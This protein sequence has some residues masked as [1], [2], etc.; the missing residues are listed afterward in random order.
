MLDVEQW[1]SFQRTANGRKSLW[2]VAEIVGGRA[3]IYDALIAACRAH[4]DDLDRIAEDVAALGYANAAAI[5]AE[6]LPQTARA[7][8]GE[9][10]EILATE[11]VENQ[12]D[13]EVPIRRLRYKDG[14]EMALRGDDFIG[15]QQDDVNQLSFLKG[16]AKSRQAMDAATIEEAR[17]VLSRDDGRPTPISLLFVADQLI[18]KGEPYANLG[19][20]LRHEVALRATPAGRITHVLF[21][22]CGNDASVFLATDLAGAD[23]GRPHISIQLRILDHQDFIRDVYEEVAALGDD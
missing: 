8:S 3:S 21:S 11:I 4:Y 17:R 13:Y 16:E 18:S 5:L 10:G 12:L 15:I 1:C 2:L 23:A 14:R 20:R 19:R 9:L 22:L 7:R 6:R